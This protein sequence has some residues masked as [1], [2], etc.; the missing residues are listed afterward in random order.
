MRFP[1]IDRIVALEPN[2]QIKAVKSPTLSEEYLHDHFPLFPVMPGVLM[3]ESMFQA[4][5]W[6]LRVSD[7]F[8]FSVI[9]LKEARNVKYSGFVRPGERLEVSAEIVKRE[10]RLT[11]VK[12]TG[13]VGK[14]GVAVARLLLECRN[15]AD[16]ASANAT[17]DQ[18]IRHKL[19]R[20]LLSLYHNIPERKN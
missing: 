13:C 9:L 14:Q 16:Q 4:A 17:I 3:L 20:E 2:S 18:I 15:L 19:R 8:Q 7:D 6:L 12:A 1:L 11:T 5:A 10:D